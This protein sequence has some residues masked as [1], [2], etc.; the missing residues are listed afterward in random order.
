MQKYFKTRLARS[1]REANGMWVPVA[2]NSVGEAFEKTDQ[3]FMGTPYRMCD[4][5]IAEL[6][7]GSSA[8]CSGVSST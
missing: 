4:F 8:I 6:P 1:D 2:A 5:T 7:R 3:A